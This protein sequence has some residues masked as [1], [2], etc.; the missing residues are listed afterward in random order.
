MS[1]PRNIKGLNFPPDLV[2]I[3]IPALTAG[4]LTVC[5]GETST[6]M[7]LQ[8]LPLGKLCVE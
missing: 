6:A 4:L 1:N 5:R 8:V 2:A 3:R 7:F